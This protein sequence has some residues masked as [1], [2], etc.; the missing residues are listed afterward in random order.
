V[1]VGLEGHAEK[2]SD[3]LH[4]GVT[5][6]VHSMRTLLDKLQGVARGTDPVPWDRWAIWSA[7]PR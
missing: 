7:I 3:P 4:L 5:M 6:P 1:A 2:F